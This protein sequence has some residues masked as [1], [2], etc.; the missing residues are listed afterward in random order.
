VA[1]V[2]VDAPS[3]L[4][5]LMSETDALNLSLMGNEFP[6]LGVKGGFVGDVPV[7]ASEAVGNRLIILH[8]PSLL[9]ADEGA[10]I[11]FSDTASVEMDDAPVVGESS[12][13][14]QISTL[15]SAWQN[16]LVLFRVDRFVNWK[17]GV[18]NRVVWLANT[19]YGG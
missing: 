8:A 5:I 18:A 9:V 6:N 11:E 16:N 12:P 3:E 13:V 1:A 4:V 7:V 10:E 14:T 17:M 15:K 19:N 2:N